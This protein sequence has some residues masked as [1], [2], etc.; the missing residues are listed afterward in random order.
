MV[1]LTF[2]GRHVDL[3][4]SVPFSQRRSVQPATASRWVKKVLVWIRKKIIHYL[5]RGGLPVIVLAVSFKQF[6]V[7]QIKLLI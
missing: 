2:Q 4:D 7:R 5:H 1:M 6:L 3:E